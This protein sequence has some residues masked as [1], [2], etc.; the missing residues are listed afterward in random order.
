MT[1]GCLQT[2]GINFFFSS[3]RDF[4]EKKSIGR[5]PVVGVRWRVVA[6]CALRAEAGESPALRGGEVVR[7]RKPPG[8][9]EGGSR[10]IY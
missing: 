9:E 8:T 10:G 4:L 6:T 3:L 2:I 1:D 7:A 5:Y